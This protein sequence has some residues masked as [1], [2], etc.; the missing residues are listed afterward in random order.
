[1][2]AAWEMGRI[3]SRHSAVVQL[4]VSSGTMDDK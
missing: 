2:V 1:M 4:L 3:A